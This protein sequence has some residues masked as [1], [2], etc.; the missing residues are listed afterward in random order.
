MEK[1]ME[2][3]IIGLCRVSKEPSAIPL[4]S[5]YLKSVGYFSLKM[6][7]SSSNISSTGL[8]GSS[9]NPTKPE[10]PSLGISCRIWV[11]LH[12]PKQRMSL[13]CKLSIKVLAKVDIVSNRSGVY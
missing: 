11:I 12:Q 4:R 3:T 8:Q 7:D 1:K 6:G 2:T 13:G 9:W 10:A 5:S